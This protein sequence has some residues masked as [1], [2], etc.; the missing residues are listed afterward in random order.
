M[1]H[2]LIKYF[3]PGTLPTLFCPGCGNGIVSKTLFEAFDE[4][5]IYPINK[6]IFVSGIGCASWIPSPYFNA[7]TIHTLHGRA[8]AVATGIKLARPDLEV[9]VV[10]GDGDIVGIGGNHLIHAARRNIDLMVIMVNNLIY[11]MTGGQVAPTTPLGMKTTTTPFGNPEPPFDTCYLVSSCGAKYVARWTIGHY[12]NLKNC[13]VKA[14]QKRGFRFIEVVSQCTSR[15]TYKLGIS[16]GQYIKDLLKKSV[17]IDKIKN[18]LE[19]TYN[20]K[21]VVGVYVDK[22]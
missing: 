22:E 7:D 2:P 21:I 9:I 16:A 20:G 11:G 19:E 12:I 14:L 13:F 8:I 10:G 1:R 18:P 3:R 5:N 17:K 4:L 15:V 6:Y